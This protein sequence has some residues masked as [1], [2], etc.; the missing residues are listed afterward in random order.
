MACRN[1]RDTWGW[2]VWFWHQCVWVVQKED[3]QFLVWCWPLNAEQKRVGRSDREEKR[4]SGADG[5]TVPGQ[6]YSR[7]LPSSSF[8]LLTI[9]LKT[10]SVHQQIGLQRLFQKW[11]MIW[12]LPTSLR[13]M[14]L[15][16][17]NLLKI[18]VFSFLNMGILCRRLKMSIA[19]KHLICLT[20][21]GHNSC[22]FMDHDLL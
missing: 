19:V 13:T 14:M 6:L 7:I 9:V 15:G 21:D 17:K 18:H 3:S 5:H 4:L 20:Q 10:T 22:S 2:E 1:S 12:N 8:R 11:E 16:E